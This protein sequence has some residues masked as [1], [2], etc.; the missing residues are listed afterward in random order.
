MTKKDK[1]KYSEPIKDFVKKR[2]NRGGFEGLKIVDIA[3]RQHVELLKEQNKNRVPKTIWE[4]FDL[5]K[6][7]DENIV[8]PIHLKPYIETLQEIAEGKEHKLCFSAPPQHQ[9]S[10]SSLMALAFLCM[11]KQN[12]KHAYIT[13]SNTRA[14]DVMYEF[15]ILLGKLGLSFYTR[16]N[17][18]HIA[19]VGSKTRNNTVYF[20]SVDSALT[21]Y[22][23]IGLAIVD[24]VIKN[25]EEAN[26]E[27]RKNRIWDF[28]TQELMTR[29]SKELSVIVMMTRWSTDDL[30]GRLIKDWKWAYYRLPA[31]CDTEDDLSG[32][33]IGQALLPSIHPITYLE[34]TKEKIGE[35]VF[36]ALYQGNPT[37]KGTNI[38]SVPT[39]YKVL[40]DQEYITT[41]GF[42]LAYSPNNKSDYSVAIRLK[43]NRQTKKTYITDVLMKQCLYTDF[44]NDLI[45]FIKKDPGTPIIHY[46][47]TEYYTSC[48]EVRKRIPNV[49]L[50]RAAT[51]KVNRAMASAD[52]WNAGFILV[53][54]QQ[55]EMMQRA[56]STICLFT[57]EQGKKDDV[58]DAL[59]SAYSLVKDI[60]FQ[61][62]TFQ[63][64]KTPSMLEIEKQ[65]KGYFSP[66]TRKKDILF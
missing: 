23:I 31:I 12:K 38:Y 63:V 41:I 34:D 21:G 14:K 44:I 8:R 66:H 39:T 6:E 10:Y 19:A 22:N 11:T 32:R 29:K 16:N 40:S 25:R 36:S 33:T 53:P 54:E 3:K 18:V 55:S 49:I 37:I 35:W 42:D 64:K 7:N 57:G 26:S 60:R 58:V 28:F 2:I 52:A 30:I 24:D 51:G 1:A 45:N 5:L 43:T 61:D 4:T 13:Y 50:V 15:Q 20:G 27:T 46:G 17:K 47:S 59:S 56:I 48:E 62:N 9:K 65:R